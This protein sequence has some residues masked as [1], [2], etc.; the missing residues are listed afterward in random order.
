MLHA[1]WENWIICVSEDSTRDM[2][3]DSTRDMDV[4]VRC[5]N[6]LH[7]GNGQKYGFEIAS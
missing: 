4:S 3:G 5:E 7:L 1:E 2:A 6:S